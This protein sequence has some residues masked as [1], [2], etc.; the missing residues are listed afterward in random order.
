MPSPSCLPL[1]VVLGKRRQRGASSL[2]SHQ[3]LLEVFCVFLLALALVL[4]RGA[5]FTHRK[6]MTTRTRMQRRGGSWRAVRQEGK[7]KES[8]DHGGELLL[9]RTTAARPSCRRS[10]TWWRPTASC[11][12]GRG[13]R[14]EE[15]MKGERGRTT[16]FQRKTSAP[17]PSTSA[18]R[19]HTTG[20]QSSTALQQEPQ[21]FNIILCRMHHVI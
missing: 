1:R 14:G 12:S 21:T 5:G 2:V 13:E 17:Y 16:T 19:C 11:F 20:I 10:G 6:R 18:T 9:G 15:P 3:L 7:R 8:K 4:S